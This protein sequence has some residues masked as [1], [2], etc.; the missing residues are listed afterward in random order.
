MGEKVS[1]VSVGVKG[2]ETVSVMK[3]T[4]TSEKMLTGLQFEG[5]DATNLKASLSR[6]DH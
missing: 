6:I 3:K 1:I 4:I 2:G 5:T